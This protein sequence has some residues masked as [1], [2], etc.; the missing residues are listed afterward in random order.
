MYSQ[1]LFNGL[2]H[3]PGNTLYQEM[4]RIGMDMG[5]HLNAYVSRDTDAKRVALRRPASQS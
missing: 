3:F 4:Q 2:V 5:P 1:M